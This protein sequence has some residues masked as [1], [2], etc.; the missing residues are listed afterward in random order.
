MYY[1]KARKY[2][3][4][5]LEILTESFLLNSLTKAYDFSCQGTRNSV[6]PACMH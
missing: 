1:S 2:V 3:F 6:I 4:L 5:L